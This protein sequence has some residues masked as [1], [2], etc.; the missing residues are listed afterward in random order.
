MLCPYRILSGFG[1][2][3]RAVAGAAKPRAVIEHHRLVADGAVRRFFSRG[4]AQDVKGQLIIKFVGPENS[5][6][7]GGL[8]PKA[9]SALSREGTPMNFSLPSMIVAGVARMACRSTSSCPSGLRM[10]TSR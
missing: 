5:Y 9:L 4:A 3:V 7:S 6:R 1:A 8:T 2:A 10:S